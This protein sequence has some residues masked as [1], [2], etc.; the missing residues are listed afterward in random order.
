MKVFVSWSGELSKE[1]AEILRINIQALLQEIDVFFSP[2][3]NRLSE[4]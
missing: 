1:I 2:Y 3:D 4:S